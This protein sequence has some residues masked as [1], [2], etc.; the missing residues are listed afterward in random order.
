[1][2]WS[3]KSKVSDSLIYDGDTPYGD[4]S[5]RQGDDKVIF[6][7]AAGATTRYAYDTFGRN[8]AVTNALGVATVYE[9][10]ARGN[11]TYEGGGTYP[12]TYAYD[13][14]NV[15]TNMTT[16]RAE[17]S[18]SGDTTTWSYDEATGLLLAKT[19]ADCKGP[20][21]TYTPNGNLATRTWARG[22][23][24][25]YSYDGWNSLTNTA[26]SDGTPAISLSYDAMGRQTNATD[27]AG[28]T[29]TS[30]N[31]FGDIVSESTTG[32]YPRSISHVRDGYG[33]DLGLSVGNSR[34]SI[35]EYEADT[36][37][38]KRVMMAG[39]WFTYYYLLGTDLKS[40]LQY[41]GSYT[42]EPNRDL[43]TQVRNHINGGVISQYD[44]VND[45]AGRRTRKLHH[46]RR[47]LRENRTAR[48]KER[49]HERL[50]QEERR[51]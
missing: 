13:A 8:V 38:V 35:I 29:A 20:E 4:T 49:H 43:L 51:P 44:Y 32:L 1:M 6:E 12:V 26:Y 2:S 47:M 50:A 46:G 21:Y 45:A 37:R 41:S 36:A 9:Y 30:Y 31:A 17:G 39:V 16:Y 23:V 48:A 11:K 42:Y 22:I 14:Y 33:R 25:T 15:M 24:T 19:Y 7:F 34:M 27:A 18:Q 40:R 3:C 5:R 10:D 28:T